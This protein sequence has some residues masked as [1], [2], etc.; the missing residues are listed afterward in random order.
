MSKK[1]RVNNQK[2]ETTERS[3]SRITVSG[4]KSIRN[5]QSI[6]IKP[7]TILAGPNNSGKSSMM[8]PLLLLKQTLEA[9]YDPGP[10]LLNGP[11]VHFTSV[12]QLLAQLSNGKRAGSFEVGIGFDP[13]F[14]A[15]ISFKK[16]GTGGFRIQ[17]I[18]LEVNRHGKVRRGVLQEGMSH[19]AISAEMSS[20][21]EEIGNLLDHLLHAPNEESRKLLDQVEQLP[22]EKLEKLRDLLVS[23]ELVVIR[24]R[25]FLDIAFSTRGAIV[26]TI[27]LIKDITI[28]RMIH[29]PGLR[30]NPERAFPV[31]AVG[32]MFPGTFQEYTASIIAQWQA[33]KRSSNLKLLGKYLE[34][35][36]LTWKVSAK[37]INDAQV[38]LQVG[39][40]PYSA[41]SGATD[42]VNIADVGFGVSQVLPVLVALL[43]A[44][45]GQLVYIEEPEIHLHPRAQSAM[46]EILADAAKRGIRVVIETHS[47]LLLLG[48]Q[49]LVAKGSLSP[50]L[51]KLHWFKRRNDG[52]TEITSADLDEA[53]TFGSWP[54][55][56]AEVA[57]E[58]ESRYLDAAESRQTIN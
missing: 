23:I 44:E 35:L 25:C 54:E 20:L 15:T 2:P 27:P 22:I 42:M 45:P 5:E 58:A 28:R 4:F 7:L 26:Q 57:L 30:G 50:D 49:T 6:D 1:A 40:L 37:A 9:T 8:Q 53:G 13:V 31:T 55:D 39:R 18:I 33:E 32:A 24:N 48:I 36:G 43:V 10:L 38:E 3:I 12:E 41:K 21:N 14:T 56:F 52:S 11:S 46:A 16:K 34:K 29:L 19:K 51:V 47:Q 17:K